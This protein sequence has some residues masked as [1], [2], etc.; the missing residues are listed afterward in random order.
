MRA[1]TALTALGVVA[2]ASVLS[3]LGARAAPPG[4]SAAASA[5]AGRPSASSQPT[6]PAP[7][8]ATSSVEPRVPDA[9]S[10]PVPSASTVPL[11][12]RETAE[13]VAAYTLNAELVPDT[14]AVRGTGTIVWRNA[15]RV[16]TSKLYVHLYLNAFKNGRTVFWRHAFADFRGDPMDGP[17]RIDVDRF[18]VRELDQDLW[19][20]DATT[21]GDPEDATDI[22][23]TLPR[24]VEPGE[25]LTIDMAWTSHLPTVT[26]RTG[27]A[28]SFH[29]VAQWFPKIARLELDG[30]WAHFPFYRLSEFYADYGTYDVTVTA[31][32]TFVV[33]ATGKLVSQ[34]PAPRPEGAEPGPSRTS[35][36]FTAEDVHDFAFTAWDGFSSIED[37]TFSG[38]KI[39][40]LFPKGYDDVA[41]VEVDTVKR[42]LGYLGAAFGRYPYSTLTI[43][44]PPPAAIEAGGM[45][46]PTMITTGGSWMAGSLE[47]RE[48][49]LLTMHELAHQWFYGL[50]GTNEHAHPFLDE[51]LTSYAEADACEAFWPDASAGRA[52]GL[53]VGTPA[54]YRLLAL[55]SNGH[56]RVSDPV[57]AFLSGADYGALV[58]S[59]TV[60]AMRTIANVYGEDALRR[61]VGGYA[62]RY[63]FAHPKPDDFFAEIEAALG[64]DA[65]A[66]L[67]E[68]LTEPSNVDY[69]AE[70]A[71]SEPRTD[72]KIGYAGHALVRRLGTIR[73]PVDVRMIAEDG[74]TKTVRWNGIASGERI[75]YQ[76][77]SRLATVVVDPD[78]RVLLDSDLTNNAVSTGGQQVA[79]RSLENASFLFG[80][81]ARGLLP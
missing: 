76:G 54:V 41:R 22:E 24:P 50:V 70:S 60:V 23:L 34:E 32:D 58:Y 80:A 2:A 73:L 7:H 35:R 26:I 67:R 28:G 6:P 30:T 75:P 9:P 8:S 71:V 79:W 52:A 47:T 69:V 42:G 25:S 14:H 27:Y 45:E 81:L 40:C 77:E 48:L 43:V 51:G 29:M 11:V 74:T 63:R 4:P 72:G 66:A 65:A 33:G 17:G 49:E 59:R 37:T 5:L 64:E 55:R 1:K 56:A 39:M 31:P 44:H 13:R 53:S 3:A 46:Y 62:R 15:S 20:K 12:M 10:A 78:H 61:A 18:F 57:P 36:R 21:P 16:A 68:A 38:V 19:Q